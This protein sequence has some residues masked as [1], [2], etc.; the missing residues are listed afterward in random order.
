MKRNSG[1]TTWSFFHRKTTVWGK[2]ILRLTFW[3]QRVFGHSPAFSTHTLSRVCKNFMRSFH[4]V[5]VTL[6]YR[7]RGWQS[8]WCYTHTHTHTHTH[9]EIPGGYITATIE[10]PH[11]CLHRLPTSTFCGVERHKRDWAKWRLWKVR[12]STW[13]VP[14]VEVFLLAWLFVLLTS[15][16]C[17]SRTFFELFSCYFFC[18][19]NLLQHCRCLE[20]DT[21]FKSQKNAIF[22]VCKSARQQPIDNKFEKTYGLCSWA[23]DG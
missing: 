15:G 11:S 18:L 22:L 13:N 8:G 12:A 19:S 16:S 1:T 21:L 9:T 3:P 23:R 6:V 10:W 5:T 4:G 14:Q 2:S 7:Q 17:T 20:S